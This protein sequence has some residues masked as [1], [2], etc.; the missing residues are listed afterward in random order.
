[1]EKGALRLEVNVSVARDGERGTKVEIKNLNSFRAVH[2]SLEYEIARQT[3]V[4]EEGGR[5]AQVTMGWDES[6][7]A[8]FEQRAKEEA[9][10][11]RYFPEPDLPPLVLDRGWVEGLRARLPELP[12]ARSERYQ[13]EYGLSPYDAGVLTADRA[14]AEYFEAAVWAAAPGVDAKMISNWITG[15]VFRLM[16]AEDRPSRLCPSHRAT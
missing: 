3:R 13:S 11:Y 9:H 7:E 4:L 14:V 16:R 10:D 12:D 6:R 8:T 2:R 5:V 15:E 1:M